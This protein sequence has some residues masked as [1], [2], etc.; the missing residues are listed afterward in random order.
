[1]KMVKKILLGTLA[2]AAVVSFASC[3]R[4]AAGNES[5]IKGSAASSKASIDY[6]NDGT[7]VTRGF[8]SLNTKHL[9][10]I[11]HIQME[12]N[13][14]VGSDAKA[15]G[16]MGYIF[17]LVTDKDAGKSSFTIAG[18]RYNQKSGAIE[19]YVETFKDV[20]TS[21]L[22]EELTGGIKAK[23]SGSYSGFGF[24][25]VSKADVK[26]L[27]EANAK[28]IDLWIDVAAQGKAD[29][30]GEMKAGDNRTGTEGTYVVKFFTKDP[31]RNSSALNY[32]L[33]Y[34]S[35]EPVKTVNVEKSEVNTTYNTDKGLTSMQADMGFYANVYAGQTLKGTWE[36][37]QI[38]KEAEEIEE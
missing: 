5:L 27:L 21:K 13:A 37:S 18:T 38:K 9:D 2:A 16:T 31:E 10:A 29:I 24:E 6:T 3:G 20:E 8:K 32:D 1:M 23:N 15:N 12:V 14:L 28:A 25:L 34:N 11:C 30:A 26:K 19:A 22:E 4:D 33:T 17:N 36:F 35:V 7:T